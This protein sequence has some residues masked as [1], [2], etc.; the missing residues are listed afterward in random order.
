MRPDVHEHGEHAP[1]V[2]GRTR[3]TADGRPS[4]AKMDPTWVSTVF[5]ERN[6]R[7]AGGYRKT[8]CWRWAAV[9]SVTGWKRNV[10]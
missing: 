5:G 1:V 3:Q 6:S 9:S 7:S 4:L 10:G 8:S 2:V